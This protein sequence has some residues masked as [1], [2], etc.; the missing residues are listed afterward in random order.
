MAAGVR[1]H[2]PQQ[3]KQGAE[4]NQ[5]DTEIDAAVRSPGGGEI[6]APMNDSGNESFLVS[7]S[8]SRGLQTGQDDLA[9]Q[10]P[11]LGDMRPGGP[12]GFGPG[13]P[14]GPGVAGGAPG[15]PGGAGGGS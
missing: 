8:L 6:A 3:A 9:Q 14:G 4:Q 12:G 10:R 1:Q 7:G 15:G 13:G 2:L 11:D 5:L